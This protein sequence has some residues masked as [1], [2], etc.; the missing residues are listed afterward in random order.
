MDAPLLV[1]DNW[2]QSIKTINPSQIEI[3]DKFDFKDGI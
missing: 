1:N 2:K 3:L